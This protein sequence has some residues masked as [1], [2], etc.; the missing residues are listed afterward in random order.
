MIRPLFV[1]CSETKRG[2]IHPAIEK[3]DGPLWRTI[4]AAD[5]RRGTPRRFAIVA[6]SAQHGLVP[7]GQRLAD[8]DCYLR[9]DGPIAVSSFNRHL[10]AALSEYARNCSVGVSALGLELRQQTATYRRGNPE[11]IVDFVGGRLYAE[12]L[13]IAGFRVR[14]LAPAGA[15]LLAMRK[16]LRLHVEAGIATATAT[17]VGDSGVRRSPTSEP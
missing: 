9:P 13:T 16:A 4:R 10:T 5:A 1:A 17:E 3:Y 6:V 11:L 12:A 15:G 8:Y 7:E 14:P 2:G